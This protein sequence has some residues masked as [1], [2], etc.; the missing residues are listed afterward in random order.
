M[1]HLIEKLDGKFTGPSSSKGPIGSIITKSLKDWMKI[2]V[3]HFRSV[4]I[5]ED[6]KVIMSALYPQEYINQEQKYF[7]DL[8]V[9]VVKGNMPKKHD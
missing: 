8:W 7:F 1:K 4:T 5:P 9:A 2:K 3:V 6:A